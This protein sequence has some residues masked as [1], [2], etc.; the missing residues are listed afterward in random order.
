MNLGFLSSWAWPTVSSV[1]YTGNSVKFSMAASAL[2]CF[3][4]RL[5]SQQWHA[6]K[7]C[8]GWSALESPNL[9]SFG[10]SQVQAM[11]AKFVSTFTLETEWC[12]L[13]QRQLDC[14]CSIRSDFE[15]PVVVNSPSA[16]SGTIILGAVADKKKDH[17]RTL[18]F[19]L[20]VGLIGT[21]A[22]F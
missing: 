21:R 15:P 8:S 10:I 20:L 14:C 7:F 13:Y 1:A 18:S 12:G 19:L 6:P 4:V 3:S 5:L 16:S 11:K 22:N 17:K 9:G 2:V